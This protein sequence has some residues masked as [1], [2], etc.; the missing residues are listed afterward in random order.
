MYLMQEYDALDGTN[1]YGHQT[2]FFGGGAGVY[3]TEVMPRSHLFKA[4]MSRMEALSS[5]LNFSL[6]GG[7]CI[8]GT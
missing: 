8:V 7:Y 3:G 1:W 6:R 2:R 4:A 5:S